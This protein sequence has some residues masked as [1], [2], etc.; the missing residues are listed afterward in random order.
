MSC[1]N[2]RSAATPVAGSVNTRPLNVVIASLGSI[3]RRHLANFQHVEPAVRPIVWHQHSRPGSGGPSA[4]NTIVYSLEEALAERPDAALVTGPSST[5]V[6]TAQALARHGVHL[7]VEKPLS[8][9]LEGV[10]LL[11]ETCRANKIILMVAYCFRF[12][13]PM[14]VVKQAIANGLIGRVLSVRAEVGSYLPEWRPASDYRTGVT[15]RRDLGGG[16][17]LELSHELDYVRWLVGEVTS[18]SAVVRRQSDLQIDVEDTAEILMELAGGAIGSVHLD[19][20]QRAPIRGC[21]VTGTDGT[22]VWNGITHEVKLYV[23]STREWSDLHPPDPAAYDEMYRAELCG[24]LAAVNGGE[25]G[26][27][28]GEDGRRVVALTL[29]ARQASDERRAVPV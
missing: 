5:H 8:N 7:L 12:Y 18:V 23:A 2:P 13:R 17:L 21:R 3:G 9:S 25:P 19:M 1:V 16:V 27:A 20:T 4:A 24:F 11:L 29:A 10:D 28:T 22:L 14:Q 26:G 6:E 15:A